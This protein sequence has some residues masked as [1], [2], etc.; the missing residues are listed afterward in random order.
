MDRSGE[1]ILYIEKSRSRRGLHMKRRIALIY[2][3][4]RDDIKEA[5]GVRRSIKPTYIIGEA[6]EVRAKIDPELYAVQIDLVMN[7][8]KKVKGYIYLYNYRGD[9]LIK[10][11]YSKL[12]LR[13]S[14]GDPKYGSVLEKIVN[15]LKIPYK[16][17][18]WTPNRFKRRR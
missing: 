2:D 6:Y 8:R 3:T 17:V 13:L 10:A 12:K 15:Y 1:I 14:A 11:K 4:K 18:N 5:E 7:P 9:L 16:N